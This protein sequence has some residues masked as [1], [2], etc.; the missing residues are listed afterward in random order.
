MW[1]TFVPSLF[2]LSLS[3]LTIPPALVASLSL[4]SFPPFLDIDTLPFPFSEY[5][6]RLG[7]VKDVSYYA[8]GGAVGQER[9][10]CGTG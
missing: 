8:V 3:P 10:Y 1:V 5:N 9:R 4:P 2:F 6:S 7:V